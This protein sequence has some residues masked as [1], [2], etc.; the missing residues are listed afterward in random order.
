MDLSMHGIYILIL[1]HF[2]IRICI[3]IYW[4]PNS[5]GLKVVDKIKKN[6]KKTAKSKTKWNGNTPIWAEFIY[7]FYLVSYIVFREKF[8]YSSYCI[9]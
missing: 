7:L 6:I 3:K 2:K 4:L 5:S 9:W 1:Q 8:L